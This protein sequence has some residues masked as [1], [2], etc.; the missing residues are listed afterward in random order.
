[1]GAI[2]VKRPG[3]AATESVISMNESDFALPD[4]VALMKEVTAACPGAET[5]L[6]KLREP[7]RRLAASRSW[8][9]R[10]RVKGLV[11]GRNLIRE[12][13]D[14]RLAIILVNWRGGSRAPAH[15]HGTLALIAGVEGEEINTVWRRMDDGDRAGFAEIE[16]VSTTAV[17]PGEVLCIGEREIHTVNTQKPALALHIYGINPEYIERNIFDPVARTVR[18]ARF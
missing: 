7:A 5:V 13:R 16:Q 12:E 3:G 14:H 15:D 10:R 6:S 4:F 17:G 8:I 11:P 1:M 9:E 2:S 18:R